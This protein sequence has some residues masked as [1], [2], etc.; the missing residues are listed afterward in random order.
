[1]EFI[2]GKLKKKTALN[3]GFEKDYLFPSGKSGF[4][5]LVEK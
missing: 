4:S 3:N 5:V 1:M 2:N